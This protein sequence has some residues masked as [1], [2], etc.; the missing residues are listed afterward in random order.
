MSKDLKAQAVTVAKEQGFSSLQEIVRV[1]LT[2]LASHQLVVKV[3]E[4]AVQLSEKAV[5]RYARMDADFKSG[6]NVYSV[7]DIDELME[8]LEA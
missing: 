7:R 4:P 6:K 8:Q 2:K 3:V 1:L 5:K